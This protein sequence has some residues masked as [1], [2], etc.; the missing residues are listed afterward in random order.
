MLESCPCRA[1]LGEEEREGW[2]SSLAQLCV[3]PGEQ[4][5]DVLSRTGEPP[6]QATMGKLASLICKAQGKR[7][8]DSDTVREKEKWWKIKP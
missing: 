5:M 1:L 6:A 2:K 4:L 3:P 8:H 7:R